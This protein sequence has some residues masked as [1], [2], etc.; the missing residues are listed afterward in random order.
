MAIYHLAVKVISRSSGRSATGAAAYRSGEKIK[1][2]KND[3]THDY[4]KKDGISHTDILHPDDAPDWVND[5]S[6]LWNEVEACEKRHD[7]QLCREVEVALPEELSLEQNKDLVESFILDEFVSKGMVADLAIHNGT[8]QNPH[9]HILLTTRSIDKNGFGKKNRDWNKKEMLE[10][11]RKSW[12]VKV[13]DRLEICGHQSKIDHRTLEAQGINR[14]PQI[15][16]GPNV[17]EMERR[18]IRT[19]RG[20]IALKINESNNKIVLLEEYKEVIENERHREIEKIEN[21]RGA[22]QRDRANGPSHGDSGESNSST[23]E[24]ATRSQHQAQPTVDRIPDENGERMGRGSPTAQGFSACPEQGSE[25]GQVDKQLLEP[26]HISVFFDRLSDRYSSAIDRILDLV[27]PLP[28]KREGSHMAQANDRPI[29][30]TKPDEKPIN[31][32][33]IDRTYL[34]ARRQL[35]AMGCEQFEVGVKNRKGQ[36]LIRHWSKAEVLKSVPWLKRENAMGSDIYVRPKSDQ[37][38][39]GLILVDDVSKGQIDKMKSDGFEPA[40]VVETSPYNHQVWLRLTS[41]EIKPDIATTVSKGMAT[42]YDG[43]QKSA[44]WKHFGR[45]SGFTNQK[46][47]HKTPR[48][49][50][51]WVLCHESSGKQASKGEHAVEAAKKSIATYHADQEQKTRLNNAIESR[52]ASFKYDPVQTY[53]NQFKELRGRYGPD[54]DLSK[55]DYMISSSMAKQ[56]FTQ[57][58]LVN[59][60]KA[61]SP[62]LPK[63]KLGHENDYCERTVKAAFANPQVQEHL[64]QSK[65]REFG[66]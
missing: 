48:G 3:L 49:L 35:D 51:P 25:G 6:M 23:P 9:A 28:G 47:E 36:M 20:N 2:E 63:R 22:G 53:Q 33:Q 42:I 41:N 1:D 15:H 24:R 66:I 7:S 40:A 4:T 55:A 52:G 18:G 5:R 65:S 56:G 46:P 34:A 32:K 13:N 27:R 12:E 14:I 19:D 60:L 61:A 59:T 29:N 26:K 8:S 62:E 58:Q 16:L 38:N 44:D 37:N 39:Q 17:S 64:K 45:L 54:M 11:W 57:K 30:Q 31:A 50:S 21:N 43:D 10:G